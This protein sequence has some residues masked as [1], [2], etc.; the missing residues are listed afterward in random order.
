MQKKVINYVTIS[1][2]LT[3]FSTL[4]PI[5]EENV[6][7]SNIKKSYERARLFLDADNK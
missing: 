2:F 3:S 6:D 7:C 1:I 4:T 5:A